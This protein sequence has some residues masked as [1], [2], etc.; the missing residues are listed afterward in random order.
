MIINGD[1]MVINGDYV[2]IIWDIASGN[3]SHSYGKWPLKSW[4][5]PLK[6]V[7]FQFAM[8]NYQRVAIESPLEHGVSIWENHL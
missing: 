3:D 6:V 2:V 7:V 5:F 4:I 1:N 8:L